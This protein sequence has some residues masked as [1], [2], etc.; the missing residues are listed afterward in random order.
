MNISATNERMYN[1]NISFTDADSCK[2]YRLNNKIILNTASIKE[3]CQ[4]VQ[5]TVKKN[6][7]FKLNGQRQ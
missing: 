2:L 6:A 5:L 1:M 3:M 4:A 7:V